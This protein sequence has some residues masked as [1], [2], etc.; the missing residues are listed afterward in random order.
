MNIE[1]AYEAPEAKGDRV[2]VKILINL[3]RGMPDYTEGQVIETGD[4]E[5]LA[6]LGAGLAEM[7]EPSKPVV[8]AIAKPATLEAVPEPP[9]PK[10]TRRTRKPLITATTETERPPKE[11]NDG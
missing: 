2:K 7:I 3:G 8:K 4:A 1:R 5:G 10:P 9:A 6:L 11:S